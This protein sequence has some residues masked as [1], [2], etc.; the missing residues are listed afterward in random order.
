MDMWKI[1]LALF[2]LINAIFWGLF[3]HTSHCKFVTQMLN[4]RCPPHYVHLIMGLT[5]F[6]LAIMVVQ[7]KYIKSIF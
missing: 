3:P 5:C 1:L 7:W 4:M 2:L 6:I